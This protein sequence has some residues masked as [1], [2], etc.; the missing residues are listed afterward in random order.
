M[1]LE[2]TVANLPPAAALGMTTVLI[3]E[4][5]QPNPLADYVVPDI[6]AAVD[7]ANRLVAPAAST[8]G[9]RRGRDKSPSGMR[10]RRRL[11]SPNPLPDR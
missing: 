7:V 11:V 2:D 3:D 5:E 6:V 4:H 9:K 8:L 1:L 10:T